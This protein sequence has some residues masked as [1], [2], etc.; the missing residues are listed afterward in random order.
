MCC[1]DLYL[2]HWSVW[3]KKG[4]V[5]F[6]SEN[7]T[8]ADIPSTWNAMEA[9]MILARL[10]SL[11]HQSLEPMCVT[12]KAEWWSEMDCFTI[13]DFASILAFIY[14]SFGDLKINLS[15][16]TKMS[17]V[18]MNGTQFMMDGLLRSLG[19]TDTLMLVCKNTF[20]PWENLF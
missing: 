1:V 7:L 16:E 5:G 15:E 6:K 2:I 19:E 18:E 8:Q 13:I 3:M 9:L 10:E 17:F 14:M 12:T 4:S 20:S 11:A